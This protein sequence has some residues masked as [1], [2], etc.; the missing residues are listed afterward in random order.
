MV[1][2]PLLV[3]EIYF[4]VKYQNKKTILWT[5]RCQLVSQIELIIRMVRR[6]RKKRKGMKKKKKTSEMVI[7]LSLCK[8]MGPWET[9]SNRSQGGLRNSLSFDVAWTIH[10]NMN[11][12]FCFFRQSSNAKTI[13]N[14]PDSPTTAPSSNLTDWSMRFS[15]IGFHLAFYYFIKL[16]R[17]L[18]E[19]GYACYSE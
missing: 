9:Q 8:R 6:K 16:L 5:F 10:Y 4:Q 3:R 15:F 14:V 19:E 11:P 18:L 1:R 2:V 13:S 17:K 7:L 12:L